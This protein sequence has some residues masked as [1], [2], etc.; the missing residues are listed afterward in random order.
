[1]SEGSTSYVSGYSSSSDDSSY[2]HRSSISKVMWRGRGRGGVAILRR[3]I[4][5][6]PPRPIR[7]RYAGGFALDSSSRDTP[8]KLKTAGRLSGLSRSIGVGSSSMGSDDSE[9]GGVIK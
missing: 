2:F 5:N 7:R 1:V 8:R 6:R 4:H 9:A 3:S